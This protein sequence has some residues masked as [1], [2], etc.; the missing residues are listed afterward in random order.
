MDEN[1]YKAPLADEQNPMTPSTTVRRPWCL[2][3][4]TW[5]G[6]SLGGTI[7][8]AITYAPSARSL[9]KPAIAVGIVIGGVTLGAIGLTI[10]IARWH[11]KPPA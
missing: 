2:V 6:A 8:S 10:D 4:G 5:L 7:A 3:I 9:E 11:L 1:P